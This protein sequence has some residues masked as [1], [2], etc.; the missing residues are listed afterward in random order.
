MIKQFIDVLKEVHAGRPEAPAPTFAP[1][2]A[3][4]TPPAR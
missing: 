1:A 4:A 2:A 3:P